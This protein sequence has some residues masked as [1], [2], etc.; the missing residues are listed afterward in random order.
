MSAASD[1][2]VMN[3]VLSVLNHK[4]ESFTL[5]KISFTKVF[6]IATKNIEMKTLFLGIKIEY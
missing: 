4:V 6:Q 2:N 3:H 5:I 1:F